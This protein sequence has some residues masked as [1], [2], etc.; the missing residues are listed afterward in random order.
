MNQ[1]VNVNRKSKSDKSDE[2]EGKP[3]VN[4]ANARKGNAVGVR[5]E[6]KASLPCPG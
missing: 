2:G 1:R 5:P 4:S 3:S 6:A